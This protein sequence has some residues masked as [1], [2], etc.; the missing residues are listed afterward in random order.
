[1]ENRNGIIRQY[2]PKKT[3]FRDISPGMTEK[4]QEII[5]LHAGEMFRIHDPI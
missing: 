4:I 3:D 5:K 2:L 1:M